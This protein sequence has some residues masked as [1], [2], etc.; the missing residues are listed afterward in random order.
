[1]KQ[2]IVKIT[3]VGVLLSA[4]I[5]AVSC[6]LNPSTPLSSSNM[7]SASELVT[8]TQSVQVAGNGNSTEQIVSE[9]DPSWRIG[10][11]IA[12][13]AAFYE[14]DAVSPDGKHVAYSVATS[15]YKGFVVRDNIPGKT[16]DDAFDLTFSPDS[17]RLSYIAE[18]GDNY[19]VVVDGIEGKSYPALV[20]SNSTE[21]I[22]C[23]ISSLVFSPN[24]RDIAY[25]V[26][27]GDKCLVVKDGVKGKA[28]D[29]IPSYIQNP[30]PCIVFSPDSKQMAYPAETGSQEFVVINGKEGKSYDHIG[31]I[32]FSPNGKHV[33]YTA[34]SNKQWF[35]VLD[36]K[37]GKHYPQLCSDPI[38][39]P[40]SQ[41]LAYAAGTSDSQLVVV[42]GKEGTYYTQISDVVY[43]PDSNRLAY[44][45]ST[46]NNTF[47]VLDG[48]EGKYY[49]N[50][51]PDDISEIIFSPNS[52]RIAY[53]V[54]Q[55]NNW[56]MVTDGQEGQNYNSVSDPV[57]SPDSQR[58]AYIADNGFLE[59]FIVIDGVEGNPY[60]FI[61]MAP[62]FS[63]DSKNIVYV[64][65][66]KDKEVLVCNG[67]Q[68]NS[69]DWIFSE[70]LN[71]GSV[72]LQSTV[73][74][75]TLNSLH[76]LAESGNSILLVEKT[77]N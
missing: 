58:F 23:P 56:F 67:L 20:P 27:I 15:D 75:D 40:D 64:A 50:I 74:F 48:G 41:H 63:P 7:T 2:Y 65:Q 18:D 49:D 11:E 59:C 4:L 53:I 57:F 32:T 66:V 29:G 31:I 54:R 1:M 46:A 3:T 55:D 6:N 14:I 19:M 44:V 70:P 51:S 5:A 36:G 71:W 8:S 28:Y 35:V 34:E 52:K 62:V 39:S 68:E 16:Y 17:Q 60:D 77:V 72:V 33:A 37:G 9:I 26:Q 45:A 30:I 43:S 42:D 21:P 10:K 69:Y 61:N 76:C 25:A 12:N 47:V 22:T 13:G 24:S 73:T 38:F